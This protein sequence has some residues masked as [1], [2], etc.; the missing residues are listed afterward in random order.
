MSSLSHWRKRRSPPLATSARSPSGP[1]RCTAPMS[2]SMVPCVT[3]SRIWSTNAGADSRVSS[4]ESST[5][6]SRWRFRVRTP[7]AMLAV[8]RSRRVRLS[9]VPATRGL[10][11]SA[12]LGAP[13]GLPGGAGAGRFEVAVADPREAGA[14]P[15]AIAQRATPGQQPASSRCRCG[16]A[17]RQGGPRPAHPRFSRDPGA[18]R[19]RGTSALGSAARAR[20]PAQ[21]AKPLWPFF[22]ASAG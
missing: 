8:G 6:S 13:G 9:G 1:A 22:R 14:L 15:P 19:P 18:P 20:A 7:A 12:G 5:P 11:C 2:S 16:G 10:V 17:A 21:P 4:T 3:A